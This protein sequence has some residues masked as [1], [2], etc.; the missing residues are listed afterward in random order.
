M[1]PL[2]QLHWRGL[3]ATLQGHVMDNDLG[4]TQQVEHGE[5]PFFGNNTVL[6]NLNKNRSSQ[7][8]HSLVTFLDHYYI[9]L[10]PLSLYR[11]L[12]DKI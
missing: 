2:L 7:V 8:L 4:T 10:L 1:R 6:L 11:H 9:M 5:E 3:L 12:C